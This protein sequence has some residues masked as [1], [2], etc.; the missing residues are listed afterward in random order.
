MND[1]ADLS[2]P[3]VLSVIPP[4]APLIAM[5]FDSPHSGL[6]L[7]A[8][9][10]PAVTPEMVRLASD[11]HVEALFAFAPDLGAP[12]LQAEFP[13]SFL[14]LNRSERDIDPEMLDA[15]WPHERRDNAATRRG[16]GLVWR[17]AWEEVPMYDRPLRVAEMEARIETYWRPYH[18]RLRQLLDRTHAEFGAVWHVNCHSMPAVGHRL[19]PD[20]PGTV[21][22]DVVVGDFDGVA[23]EP[24]FVALVRDSLAAM[25]YSVALNKP[26]RGAE[27]VS[28][29]GDPA[30][31]RNSIQIEV[32]RALYMDEATR[33]RTA[34]FADLAA[35]LARLG[36]IM[37]GYVRDRTA[38]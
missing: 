30:S 23:S 37:A 29:Y 13:R 1:A 24:D 31:G 7:P 26:F 28:A 16:M 38:G 27:L 15:P 6:A 9:F 10:H 36:G 35:N 8:D 34:G 17:Y 12:L 4:R 11:T 33:E 21:R 3:G 19:S 25:G 5:V 20:P 14:A 22:P 32:N 18:S 2:I